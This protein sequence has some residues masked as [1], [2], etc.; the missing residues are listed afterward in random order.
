[1]KNMDED[2][3]GHYY[4]DRGNELV[5]LVFAA[6]HSWLLNFNVKRSIHKVCISRK[7]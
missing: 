4:Y 3:E 6:N 7:G 5:W 1:M 2:T